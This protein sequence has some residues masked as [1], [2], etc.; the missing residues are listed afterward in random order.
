MQA[1]EIT[2]KTKSD[3]IQIF[4]VSCLH[5]GHRGHDKNK[6]YDYRDYILKTPDTYAISLG[7][8]I[9]NAIPG[10][11]KHNQM[12]FDQNMMPAEQY[13]AACE[14]WKPVVEKG[15]LLLTADSNHWYRSQAKTGISLAKQMNIFLNTVAKEAKTVA[16]KWGQWM[17]Y[18]KLHV[19]KQSYIIHGW[20]GS[21]GS[22]TPEATLRNCRKQAESH[23]ANIYLIGHYHKRVIYEDIYFEWPDGTPRPIEKKRVYGATGCFLKWEDSYAERAGFPPAVRGAIRVQLGAKEWDVNVSL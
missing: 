17:S 6:A 16:P 9:E 21:G 3:H 4:S 5:I 13:E 11:E 7:D 8:D 1:N 12:V 2:I 19:N 20:H 10:D 23:H 15:K 22:T 18:L 14:F